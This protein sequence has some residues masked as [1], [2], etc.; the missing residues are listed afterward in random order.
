[1]R[2]TFFGTAYKL[3]PGL[4]RGGSFAGVVHSPGWFSRRG[5]SRRSFGHQTSRHVALRGD[6]LPVQ[7]LQVVGVGR[8]AD[9]TRGDGVELPAERRVAL[10]EVGVAHDIAEAVLPE[11]PR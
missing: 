6:G 8:G 4:R 2:A 9:G 5:G 7:G 1:M 10:A 11:L 3:G